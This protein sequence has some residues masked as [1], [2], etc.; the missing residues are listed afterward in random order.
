MLKYQQ[1]PCEYTFRAGASPKRRKYANHG[2]QHSAGT[3]Y[4]VS[5]TSNGAPE[6][7]QADSESLVE[8][9]VSLLFFIEVYS[10][11]LKVQSLDISREHV[12]TL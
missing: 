11:V 7:G 8:E 4:V 1:L 3:R 12:P 2:C 10:T 6:T 5:S 9:K